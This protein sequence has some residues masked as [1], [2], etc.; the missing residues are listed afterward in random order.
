MK[1]SQNLV[2]PYQYIGNLHNQGLDYIA[3]NLLSFE[4]LPNKP[5][6]FITLSTTFVSKT[7]VFGNIPYNDLEVA[8]TYALNYNILDIYPKEFTEKQVFFAKQAETVFDGYESPFDHIDEINAKIDDQVRIILLSELAE[9]EQVPILCGLAVAKS[10]LY[11]WYQQFVNPRSYWSQ[12][13]DKQAEKSGNLK[14][15]WPQIDWKAVGKADLKGAVK[16]F[17]KGL[18]TGGNVVAGAVGGAIEASA[19]NLAGQLYDYYFG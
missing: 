7:N 6:I 17:I 11:Y 8:T 15:N 13:N 5:D 14:I 12:I 4:K 3:Q 16:G 1:H 18:F 9:K 19:T 10:S 2:N